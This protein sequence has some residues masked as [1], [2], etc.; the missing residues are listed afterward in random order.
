MKE[1]IK[2]TQAKSNQTPF[3]DLGDTCVDAA[4]WLGEP[5]EPDNPL[6]EGFIEQGEV[7][8]L[9]G[10]AK[11]GKSLLALL[12]AV[13]IAIGI[14]FLGRKTKRS[15]VYVANL[16]VSSREYKRRLRRICEALKVD[17]SIL[18]GWLVVD[19]LKGK[20]ASWEDSLKRCLARDCTVAM[21]DPFYRMSRIVETD[22]QQCLSAIE[23]ME[24]FTT[25]GITLF[26]A[27]HAPKGYSGD[28][29]LIDMISGSSVLAR[30]PESIIGLLN[31]AT[32]KT[33]RVIDA[34][35]RNYPPP[36]PFA[37]TINNGV[38][39]LASEVLPDVASAR[40]AWKQKRSEVPTIDIEPYVKTA[41]DSARKAAQDNNTQFRGL[42]KGTLSRKVRAL[43]IED[44]KT[45]PGV[46]ATAGLIEGLPSDKFTITPKTGT[47]IMV[48]T[49]EDMKWYAPK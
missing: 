41:L 20:K 7:C 19:N 18:R 47:G 6:V 16:E 38:L 11:A 36:E 46:N 42:A 33:A 32:N 27:F 25:A 17:L 35:L 3:S 2:K 13:C 9:V 43:I 24:K 37:V 26:I 14:P 21:I 39:E 22:E 10:Q 5:D 15:K 4:D 44:G 34:E 23:E 28:R 29:Q 1:P 31:H 45:A 12:L 49:V 30:F 48:G 8:A 40:K